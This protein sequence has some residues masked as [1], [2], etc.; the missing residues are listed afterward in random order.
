M[1]QKKS[2]KFHKS[3]IFMLVIDPVKLNLRVLKLP[4]L[5]SLEFSGKPLLNNS[6]HF[7]KKLTF[8][9]LAFSNVLFNKYRTLT[10][11]SVMF[12]L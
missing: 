10:I 12:S 6:G 9:G 4:A 7:F 5:T 2:A 3:L 11:R 8:I 1:L